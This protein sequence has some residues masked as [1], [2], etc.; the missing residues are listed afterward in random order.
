MAYE[1]KP[2]TGS[3]FKNERKAA[4][5]HPDYQG[6][7]VTPEGQKYDLSLWVKKSQGGTSYFS[8]GVRPPYVRPDAPAETQ[9][10]EQ[11]AVSSPADSDALPF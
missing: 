4:E 2:G 11:S 3:I 7:I 5:N 10:P 9:Q 1:Q 8:V 6:S